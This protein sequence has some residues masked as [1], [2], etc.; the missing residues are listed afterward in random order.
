MK[1]VA[2]RVGAPSFC[3]VHIELHRADS[4]LVGWFSERSVA[5][6][7]A[8][9]VLQESAYVVM[10]TFND[11]DRLIAEALISRRRVQPEKR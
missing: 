9:E 1:T 5:L 4:S 8:R 3:G 2:K 11:D 6:G 10:Q 7:I